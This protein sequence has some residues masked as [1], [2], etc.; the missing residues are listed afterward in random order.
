MVRSRPPSA[1]FCRTALS[2]CGYVV[3]LLWAVELARP[4]VPEGEDA[5][6]VV[7]TDGVGAA[8]VVGVAV[9]V[10]V[11]VAVAV[12]VGVGVGV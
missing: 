8:V 1:G 11:G 5:V 3:C 2:A 9:G 4:L 12:L 10:F 6:G 7:G